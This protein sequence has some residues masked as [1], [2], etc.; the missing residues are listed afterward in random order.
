[1]TAKDQTNK[2]QTEDQTKPR[3]NEP[4][5]LIVCPKKDINL[6]VIFHLYKHLYKSS[7]K[8]V[9]EMKLKNS[10]ITIEILNERITLDRIKYRH[11]ILNRYVKE[12]ALF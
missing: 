9:C 6:T 8:N 12:N 3:D 2:C 10:S 4:L 1:M 7:H 11:T 5:T